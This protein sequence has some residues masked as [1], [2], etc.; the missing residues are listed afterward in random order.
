M[1]ATKKE[2][3][4]KDERIYRIPTNKSGKSSNSENP[5]SDKWEI[6]RDWEAI[7]L[8]NKNGEWRI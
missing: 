3:N 6:P 5:A 4:L 8:I 7:K 2:Q 1:A